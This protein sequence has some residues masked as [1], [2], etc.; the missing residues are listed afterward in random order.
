MKNLIGKYQKEKK[1]KRLIKHPIANILLRER[2]KPK[3]Q[4]IQYRVRNE[5]N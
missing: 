2:K 1:D 3:N 5:K 4:R